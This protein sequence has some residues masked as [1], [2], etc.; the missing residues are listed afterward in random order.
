MKRALIETM[1]RA[2]DAERWSELEGF[3]HPGCTYDRPGFALIE[4]ID[5]VMGFYCNDR[6]IRSGVHLIEDVVESER[7]ACAIGSFEGR[8]KSG[9]QISLRF[10]DHYVFEADRIVQRRTFFYAP[11]A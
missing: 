7:T 4:G 9:S 3:Y 6:P 8:L 10:A 11:L 1:F 2:V 5:S